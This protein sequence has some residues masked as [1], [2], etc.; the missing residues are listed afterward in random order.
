MSVV[1]TPFEQDTLRHASQYLTGLGRF[2]GL[3]DPERHPVSD[4]REV[5]ET[6]DRIHLLAVS[7]VAAA[8]VNAAAA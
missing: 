8:S 2:L 7:A 1:L 3:L 4:L 6:L 5:V